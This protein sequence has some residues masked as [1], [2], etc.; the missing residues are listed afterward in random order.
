MTSQ[1]ITT[2]NEPVS[3]GN[4]DFSTFNAS[5]TKTCSVGSG[6]PIYG[7]SDLTY[8]TLETAYQGSGTWTHSYY[9]QA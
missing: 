8:T 3:K 9:T 6:D 7:K 2:S 4:G 1:K 5:Y